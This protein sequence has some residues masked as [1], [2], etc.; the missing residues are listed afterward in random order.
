MRKILVYALGA[1]SR[2]GDDCTV[3]MTIVQ[4]RGWHKDGPIRSYSISA[5]NLVEW[6]YETLQPAAEACY[7]EIPTYNYSKDGCRWCNAKAECD[8]YKLNQKGE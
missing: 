6:A 7:E 4:P 8:T 3:Q 5:I 1:L 2:Y